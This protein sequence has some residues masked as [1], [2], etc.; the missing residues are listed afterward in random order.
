MLAQPLAKTTYALKPVIT[1]VPFAVNGID[2]Y[3]DTALLG[4]K[5]M[6]TAQQNGVIVQSTAPNAQTGRFF[7][8]RLPVGDY[9]V[10]LTADGHATA[11]IAAVPVATI[12]SVVD[13]STGA[14]PIALPV[15]ATHNVSGTDISTADA[16]ENFTLVP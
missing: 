6:V 7:L 10:V 14:A 5:V 13:I 12:T 9:G 11:V 8:G 3:V 4:S 15:S 2:G 1:V 16:T